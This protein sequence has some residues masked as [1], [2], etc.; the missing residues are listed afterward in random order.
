MCIHS[1]ILFIMIVMTIII[2]MIMMMIMPNIMGKWRE[3][4]D[5]SNWSERADRLSLA[6]KVW[7]ENLENPK[8]FRWHN[9]FYPIAK[10]DIF[11]LFPMQE[12]VKGE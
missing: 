12:S 11:T 2:M 8:K 1:V 7:G 6:K 3:F 4:V 10:D 9:F 5:M